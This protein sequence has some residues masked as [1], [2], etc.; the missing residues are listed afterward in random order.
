[1]TA[2]P[3]PVRRFVFPIQAFLGRVLGRYGH[4]S[5]APAPVNRPSERYTPR[6]HDQRP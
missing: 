5:D 6:P 2:I 1:M 3:A 4:F